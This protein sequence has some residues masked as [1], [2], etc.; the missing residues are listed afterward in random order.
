MTVSLG[1]EDAAYPFSVLKKKDAVNDSVGGIPV[2][3]FWGPGYYQRA[4]G[5]RWPLSP[6][7]VLTAVWRVGADQLRSAA[8]P[9]PWRTWSSGPGSRSPSNG[10]PGCAGCPSPFGGFRLRRSR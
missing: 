8:T 5:P 9:I 3:V 2:V 4:G 1:N 10:I 6:P 7:T